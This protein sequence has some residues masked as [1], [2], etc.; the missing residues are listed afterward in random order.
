MSATQDR[1]LRV[2]EW[3]DLHG[4]ELEVYVRED[5]VGIINEALLAAGDAYRLAASLL[6][7]TPEEE[8]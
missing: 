3:A 6:P 4:D 8:R 2:M 5:A 1:A 7:D